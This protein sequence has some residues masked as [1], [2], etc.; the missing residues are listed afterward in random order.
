MHRGYRFAIRIVNELDGRAKG[1]ALPASAV[2]SCMPMTMAMA[3]SRA[4]PGY[5]G[6]TQ[7]YQADSAMQPTDVNLHL[8][9]FQG[10][11]SEENVFLSTLSTPAH[12]CE[13]VITIPKSQPAGTYFYHPHAHGM[14]DDEVAG[15]LAGMWIVEP[16]TPQIARQ[17][18]H[19]V[20]LAY[21]VPFVSDNEKKVPRFEL[22]TRKAL[23]H[24]LAQKND[25]K[26]VTYD[27]F[28]PPP[29]PSAWPIRAAGHV[30]PRCGV[31]PESLL[32]VNGVGVPAKLTVP[33]GE[34]QLLRIL[35]GTADS[36]E[37]VQLRD[38]SGSMREMQIVGRDGVP[39]SGDSDHPLS[40][41]IAMSGI[42]LVPT[43]RA[44]VLLTLKPGEVLTVSTRPNC[45][46]FDENQLPHA[47]GAISGRA[48]APVRARA[49][50]GCAP[51]SVHVYGIRNAEHRQE[52]WTRRVL[53]HGNQQHQLP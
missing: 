24:E 14:S 19:D 9:G 12:A 23:M 22:F 32:A 17:N 7:H 2:P 53:H 1:A 3:Q 5:L 48:P 20:V 25:P 6:H 27:P 45:F 21:R 15:G 40:R 11:A 37:Y 31:F 28:D 49:C 16:D 33:A 46:M 29:W 42:E 36:F 34:P 13:Y 51:A 39:V 26:P 8:H 43:N 41:Y 10:P 52:G 4:A 44:D 38:S 47:S 50:S 35:N 18:E 30:M